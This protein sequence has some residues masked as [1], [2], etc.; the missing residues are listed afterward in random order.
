M[1]IKIVLTLD[2][3]AYTVE[4]LRA[5]ATHKIRECGFSYDVELPALA[6]QIEA[7]IEAARD[8]S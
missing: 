6:D 3:P 2:D 8:E 7:Q 4:A 1:S 5:S